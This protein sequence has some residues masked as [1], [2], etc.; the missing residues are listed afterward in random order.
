MQEGYAKHGE[1]FTVPVAHKR[2]TF[3]LGPDAA[4]HF[5]RAG[6][7]EMSQSEVCAATWSLKGGATWAHPLACKLACMHAWLWGEGVQCAWHHT[8]RCW[9]ER[10]DASA[11]LPPTQVY[12]FNVPTFGKG[13]VFDVDQKIRNEQ[14]RFFT[15]ALKKDRLKSYVPQFTSEAEVSLHGAGCTHTRA[16][17]AAHLSGRCMGGGHCAPGV[18]LECASSSI[19]S[20]FSPAPW[21]F[22]LIQ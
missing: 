8:H 16:L 10:L 18:H 9:W 4:P 3:L 12:D 5:F 15:E 21:I 6:D 1:A 7:D 11:T 19:C 13:V 14:F 22:H 17:V 2:I 20:P